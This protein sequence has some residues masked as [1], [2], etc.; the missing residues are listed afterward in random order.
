MAPGFY[1]ASA[2]QFQKHLTF[3]GFWTSTRPTVDGTGMIFEINYNCENGTPSNAP[4][5]NKYSVRCVKVNIDE[6]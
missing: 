2:D 6:E 1:N 4:E 3:A 5:A